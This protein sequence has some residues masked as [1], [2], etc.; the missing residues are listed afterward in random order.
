MNESREARVI[1]RPGRLR[2]FL[3]WW[4][5]RPWWEKALKIGALL[6][7]VYNLL[8]YVLMWC[9]PVRGVVVDGDTGLAIGGAEVLKAAEGPSIRS[10]AI[11][12]GF[13]GAKGSCSTDK[14][15]FFSFPAQRGRLTLKET[16]L[17]VAWW[18]IQWISEIHLAVWHQ[19]YV[20]ADSEKAG[21]WWGRDELKGSNG[22]CHVSRR[23]IPVLGYWYRIELKRPE[24][25][26]E[27][28]AKVGSVALCFDDE[29][30][31]RRRFIDLSGYLERWPE[32]E[33][34]GRFLSALSDTAYLCTPD[35]IEDDLSSKRLTKA[36]LAMLYERDV[37]ILEKL[38]Q[39]PS[40]NPETKQLMPGLSAKDRQFLE[41]SVQNLQRHLEEKGEDHAR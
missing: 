35:R 40:G 36:D 7:I 5:I 29:T 14:H 34:A 6:V 13:F 18:P 30:R 11:G 4:V 8:A 1:P 22:Y 15:G 2:R 39:I 19:D 9:P 10:L 24:N 21:L 37:L 17:S 41:L 27:W 25:E 38:R 32:G 20:G 28:R 33:N 23:R 12:G 31:N 3:K 16:T 26:A